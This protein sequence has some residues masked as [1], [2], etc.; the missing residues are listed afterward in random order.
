MLQEMFICIFQQDWECSKELER[1]LV[2]MVIQVS[3]DQIM[4]SGNTLSTQQS[5][6]LNEIKEQM[7]YYIKERKKVLG[8][9]YF[10]REQR[11]ELPKLQKRTQPN[12]LM[13]NLYL[14]LPCPLSH[15]SPTNVLSNC[16]ISPKSHIEQEQMPNVVNKD[17]TLPLAIK[18]SIKQQ[19]S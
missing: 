11:E 2:Y 19:N 14:N 5:L 9:W 18:G 15:L 3:K 13:I 8:T 4:D 7:I 1:L 12:Y 16:S 17:D 6:N 10:V